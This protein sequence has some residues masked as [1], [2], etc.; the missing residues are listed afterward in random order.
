MSKYVWIQVLQHVRI[1]FCSHL[2]H[3]SWYLLCLIFSRVQLQVLSSTLKV[4]VL[5][6]ISD[7]IMLASSPVTYCY[8]LNQCYTEHSFLSETW[9][10]FLKNPSF[11]WNKTWVT[12]A[13]DAH[14][15]VGTGVVKLANMH[16][17]A[18]VWLMS[19]RLFA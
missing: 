14:N 12:D 15:C 17:L 13:D 5:S 7:L 19:L 8:Y 10:T 11:I 1:C 2:V 9:E 18:M 6:L 16:T 4:R 3:V